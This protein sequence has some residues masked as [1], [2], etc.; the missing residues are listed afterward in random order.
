MI[1]ADADAN[2]EENRTRRVALMNTLQTIRGLAAKQLGVGPDA[3]D[4]TAAVDKLGIDSFG[5]LE[6]LFELEDIVGF[7]IPREALAREATLAK[8]AETID[9]MIATK[10][11]SSK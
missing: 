1:D 6:I 7:P 11:A 8:L 9:G 3:I 5:A 10:A 4:E 2:R